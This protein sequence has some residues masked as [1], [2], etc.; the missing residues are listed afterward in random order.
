MAET[1]LSISLKEYKKEI[2]ELKGAL[3]SLEKGSKEYGVILTEIRE[4]EAKLKEVM[5]DVKKTADA[6]EDTMNGLKQKL[7]ELK[8][9][10]GNEKLG[11]DKFNELSKSIAETT[12]KLKDL[13][14]QQGTYSRNVGNYESAT[15]SLKSQLKELT[16]QMAEMLASGVSPTD[17][18]FVELAKKA[19]DMK[20]AMDDARSSISHFADDTKGLATVVDLAKTGAAAYG[21][22]KG[23]LSL[24]G[25]ENE[26]VNKSLETMVA[27]TTTLNSLQTLQTALVDRSSI[28]YRLYHSV[29]EALGLS[30]TKLNTATATEATTT[31]ASTAT[32][33]AHTGAMVADT[34]ATGAA[35]VATNIFKKAL[36]STGIGAIVVLIGT[37]IANLGDLANGFKKIGEWLV[38]AGKWIGKTTGLIKEQTKAEQEAILT[39]RSEEAALKRRIEIEKRYIDKQKELNESNGKLMA[40]FVQLKG[41][42]ESLSTVQERTQFIEK[43]KNEMSSLGL[44]INNVNDA[45]RVFSTEGLKAFAKSIEMRARLT[46]IQEKLNQKLKEMMELESGASKG[47][48]GKSALGQR[49]QEEIDDLTAQAVEL[50]KMIET[51]TPTKHSTKTTKTT[52]GKDKKEDVSGEMD[53]FERSLDEQIAAIEYAYDLLSAKGEATVKDEIEKVSSIYT[54]TNNMIQREIEDRNRQLENTKITAEQRKQIQDELYDLEQ[55][56]IDVEREYTIESEKLKL[57]ARK[58]TL[59]EI[60]KSTAD[61]IQSENAS[62]KSSSIVSIYTEMLKDAEPEVASSIVRML[63]VSD[64]DKEQ[65][66][67]NIALLNSDK[68]EVIYQYYLQEE[69]AEYQHQQNLLQ[70]QKDAL[71]QM[72]IEF[73]EDSEE[74]LAQK[75]LVYDQE[76]QIARKHFAN[77][78]KMENQHAKS[79]KKNNKLTKDNYIDMA[80]GIGSIMDSVAGMMEDDIRNKEENGEITKEEAEKQFET[81]KALQIVSATIDMLSGAVQAYTTA[82]SLGPIAGPIVGGINAAAVTAMGIANI[83]QIKSQKF[84]S[85]S[86]SGASTPSQATREAVNIDFSGVSV[87][88]LLDEQADINRMTT[89]SETQEKEQRVVILQSDIYDSMKQVEVRQSNTTF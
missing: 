84:G 3:L 46:I 6:S 68:E 21:A 51:A 14:A 79:T 5:S 77:L 43:Y 86:T 41:I 83:N 76:E 59:D 38:T 82:Q 8:Q 37:L 55:E 17:K 32:V 53:K 87:N 12:D 45:E 13:E 81:V 72:G 48:H 24:F 28:T 15:A 49:L 4:K 11:S 52:S 18:A 36:I 1:V 56:R 50:T 61:A 60:K 74:Y 23:T 16:Q 9:E 26:N 66:I 89:L 63:S 22:F 70:I 78:E 27:I 2:D 80:R 88:P 29:I 85:S 69:D 39:A 33:K 57:K 42:W 40:S 19:G 31:T 67:D 65:I 54:V 62:F 58:E 73:G 35:T 20:D 64:E 34:A 47:T 71:V 7:K 25:I 75:Q 44:E 10:I 30:K